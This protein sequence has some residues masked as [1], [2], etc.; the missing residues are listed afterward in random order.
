MLTVRQFQV[1]HNFSGCSRIFT[2]STINPLFVNLR[3]ALRGAL[4]G[5]LRGKVSGNRNYD[6]ENI[7]FQKLRV[8]SL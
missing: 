8:A 4:R 3:G 5:T 7:S 1:L 6:P 2:N